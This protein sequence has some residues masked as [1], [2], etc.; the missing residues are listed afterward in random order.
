[1]T[2]PAL[3]I[4]QLSFSLLPVPQKTMVVGKVDQGVVILLIGGKSIAHGQAL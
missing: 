3:D 2:C 1:M 4:A